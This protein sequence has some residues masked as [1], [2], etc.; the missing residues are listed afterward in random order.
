VF[1]SEDGRAEASTSEAAE[2]NSRAEVAERVVESPEATGENG[3]AVGLW[4]QIRRGEN[5]RAFDV[6]QSDG[7]AA[8]VRCCHY[9]PFLALF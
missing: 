7:A 6:L 8:I 9:S 3:P 2:E 5:Q 4:A 1:G